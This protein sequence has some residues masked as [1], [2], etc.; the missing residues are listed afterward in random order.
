MG[1]RPLDALESALDEPVTVNLK[2][3]TARYGLLDGYDQHMNV[4]L[5]PAERDSD[6]P[7]DEIPAERIR[8]T[9]VIR[10]DNVVSVEL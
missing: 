6:G 5:A 9:T 4:V 7:L 2:D 3:G 8:D 1:D 10:G